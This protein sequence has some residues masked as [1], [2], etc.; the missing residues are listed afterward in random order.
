MQDEGLDRVVIER[1]NLKPK[2]S[3]DLKKWKE[4]LIKYKNPKDKVKIGLVGK[5]VE[6]QD[7]YKSILEAFI[8]AGAANEVE[9]EV[10]TIHSEFISENNNILKLNDLDGVLVA[11]G[12]GER[13]IEG[14][15]KAVEFVRINKIPFFGICLGM[16]MAVIEYSRNV[17]DLKEANSTEM[18][19]STI[20]PVIDLMEDQKNIKNKGGTMRLGS[21]ECSLSKGSLSN[22][23]YDKTLI[24]ERHRHRYEFNNK[25]NDIMFSLNLRATGF[26]PQTGLIEIIENINH[27]W[28]IGVQFHP[29]YKSTVSEPHPLFVSFIEA[30]LKYSKSKN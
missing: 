15:I 23:I 8:H 18:T 3:P 13:G 12:F 27:P 25:Y 24:K 6:L 2:Q 19:E 11:P 4:F 30:A 14:K 1:L 28:F 22:R 29:E 17:L 10:I 16:Q 21:W 7:S 9:V 20:N 26:N 5:Y